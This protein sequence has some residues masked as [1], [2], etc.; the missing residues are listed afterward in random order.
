[1]IHRVH[2]S[3]RMTTEEI[4]TANRLWDAYEA[5][6]DLSAEQGKVA[7]IEPH[8][9]QIVI[10]DTA[11]DLLAIRGSQAPPALLKRIGSAAFY[12]KGGRR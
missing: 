3:T 8:S 2:L 7:A 12:Q 9:G 11:G 10:A 6:H 5:S 1:M 4:D